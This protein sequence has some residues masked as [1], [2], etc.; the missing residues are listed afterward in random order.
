MTAGNQNLKGAGKVDVLICGG[1][2]VALALIIGAYVRLIGGPVAYTGAQRIR[3]SC[4]CRQGALSRREKDLA[5]AACR[6]NDSGMKRVLTQTYIYIY[7]YTMYMYIYI[8]K[9]KYLFV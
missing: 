9:F 6:W 5:C 8:Y 3:G 7:M 4:K 1:M 2:M